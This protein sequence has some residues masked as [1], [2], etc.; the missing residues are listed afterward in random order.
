MIIYKQCIKE[1][2][3]PSKL[4]FSITYVEV[5]CYGLVRTQGLVLVGQNRKKHRCTG[6]EILEGAD[7]SLPDEL[8]SH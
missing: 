8:H 3:N 7:V 5:I 1:K 6:L 4:K 2:L